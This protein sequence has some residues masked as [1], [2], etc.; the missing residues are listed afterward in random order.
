MYL[1]IDI[2]GPKTLV[3][4]LDAKGVIQ[5]IEEFPTPQ[6]YP[7]FITQLSG[8]IKALGVKEWHGAAAGVPAVV[9]YD[10]GY[11]A[12]IANLAWREVHLKDDLTALVG[13]EVLIENDANLA[14]L[15][16]AM[17]V[18][19]E[20]SDVLYITVSTGIGSGVITGQTINPA[21]AH[22]EPGHMLLEHEGELV[23]WEKFASGRAI[24]QKYGMYAH[25]IT[26]PND[27]EDIAANIAQ[28]L[29]VMQ[30]V[31]QPDVIII[32]GSIGTYFER[33]RE[34]L[35]SILNRHSTA[36]VPARPVIAARRP[37]QAVLFG[38]YDLAVS[39]KKS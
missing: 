18:K 4:S 7:D 24:Y 13:R 35:L 16:E 39:A 15:S 31:L 10:H 17:L 2:G 27:W 29:L 34:Q 37:E 26:D 1:G 20:Y 11:I 38:C 23:E 32:G 33:Y 36:V 28:G 19:D 30:A 21:L 25:D 5:H 8:A 14:G 12:S 3:A 6:E 9:E 22:S